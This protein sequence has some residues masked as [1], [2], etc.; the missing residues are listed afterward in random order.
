MVEILTGENFEQKVLKSSLPVLVDFFATWCGPCKMVAPF[1]EEIA[2]ENEG[3]ANVYKLDVDDKTTDNILEK[4]GIKSVP[5]LIFFKNGEQK[6]K[7]E[8][9][10]P[11]EVMQEK[12]NT[13]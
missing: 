8:R 13:L 4:Y 7:I 12:L 6:E 9:A 10:V 2:V 5:T 3:R 1:V 11:K